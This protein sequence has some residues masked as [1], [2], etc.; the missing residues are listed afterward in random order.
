MGRN[1]VICCDGTNNQFGICNTDVVRIVQICKQEPDVQLTYY[2]P[3]VGTI[4]EQGFVTRVGKWFSEA[5]ALA[6]GTDIEGKVST[7]YAHLMEVWQPGDEVYVLGFSRGAYTARMLAG[8]LHALGLLPPGNAH[9]LPYVMRLYSSM[10]NNT[11]ESFHALC[12]SFRWS[13]ARPCGQGDDR[14]FPVHFLGLWDTVSSVGW[15]WNP[16]TYPYTTHNPSVKVVRHAVALDERRCFFRQNLFSPGA[17]QDVKERWFAGVHSDVGG[18]YPERDGGLWRESFEWML[19]EAR[20]AGLEVDEARLMAVTT[21]SPVPTKPWAEQQH[22]SL[23][24]VWWLAEIFPKLVYDFA[25]NRKRPQLGLGRSRVVT[26]GAVIS[27]SAMKK[28]RDTGYAPRNLRSEF[29]ASARANSGPVAD[30]TYDA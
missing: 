6:F 2:D 4:P 19:A 21:S 5:R 28:M 26:R 13:F 30:T 22:E 18:G 3:G 23:K 8:L 14:H 20:A 10:R 7:A 11:G 24:G 27:E 29:I 17:G 25:R 9:L 16:A 12:D 1:I 15:I